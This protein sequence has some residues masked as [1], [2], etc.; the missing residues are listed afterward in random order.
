MTAIGL[1]PKTGQPICP[2]F[3][4][5]VRFHLGVRNLSRASCQSGA[6]PLPHAPPGLAHPRPSSQRPCPDVR[7]CSRIDTLDAGSLELPV[8]N[9]WVLR[10]RARLMT[11]LQRA[12]SA[13]ISD[14]RLQPP[15]STRESNRLRVRALQE[16]MAEIPSASQAVEPKP[17]LCRSRVRHRRAI[18]RLRQITGKQ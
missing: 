5:D 18:K 3:R 6:G 9:S 8:K 15:S 11:F 2:E 4:W 17:L 14:K 10:R 13:L 1:A 7:I 12:R 16:T